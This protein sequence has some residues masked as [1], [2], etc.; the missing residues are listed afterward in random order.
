MVRLHFFHS[1]LVHGARVADPSR[2]Q[3]G[4]TLGLRGRPARGGARP[5][6]SPRGL[7]ARPARLISAW[8][9]RGEGGREAAWGGA[10]GARQGEA[11]CSPRAG[12][13]THA[14]PSG[15][16]PGTPRW[17]TEGS[18]G[19]GGLW[20]IAPR[21]TQ[22]SGVLSAGLFLRAPACAPSSSV[23]GVP[24]MAADA[25]DAGSPTLERSADQGWVAAGLHKLYLPRAR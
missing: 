25:R 23:R 14:V 12:V 1:F 9:T 11:Q 19:L 16:A 3:Q 10:A 6:R 2:D 17:L 20:A 7:Q 4:Q 8:E 22:E 5:S 15:R 13:G 21:P 24:V 18:E